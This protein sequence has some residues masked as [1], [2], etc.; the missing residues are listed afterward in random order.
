[1]SFSNEAFSDSFG[2]GFDRVPA[3]AITGGGGGGAMDMGEDTVRKKKDRVRED[4]LLAME[5]EPTYIHE[6]IIE[7]TIGKKRKVYDETDDIETIL[8]LDN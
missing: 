1:M 2:E 5:G 3:V 4:L 6:P 8:W 7:E